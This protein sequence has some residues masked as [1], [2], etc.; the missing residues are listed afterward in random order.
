MRLKRSYQ[1]LDRQNVQQYYA[2]GASCVLV[3]K[4][5]KNSGPTS[6][7]T[8]YMLAA[9]QPYIGAASPELFFLFFISHFK[10]RVILG[11]E[12]NNSS[13]CLR[14]YLPA[15]CGDN[16]AAVRGIIQGMHIIR[17]IRTASAVPFFHVH[18]AWYTGYNIPGTILRHV[19]YYYTYWFVCRMS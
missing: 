5:G 9:T 8:V 14:S 13:S 16:D 3:M 4:A 12:H 18:H 2:I 7:S 15:A 10:L 1:S 6:P 19:Y 17:I 11:M